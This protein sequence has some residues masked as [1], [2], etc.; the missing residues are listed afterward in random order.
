V[1]RRLVLAVV[2]ATAAL[3]TVGC[4][5]RTGTSVA[6]KQ[7]SNGDSRTARPLV[8][9]STVSAELDSLAAISV[10]P[11]VH[12]R[13]GQCFGTCEMRLSLYRTSSDG[14]YQY[15]GTRWAGGGRS[16]AIVKTVRTTLTDEQATAM[17]TAVVDAGLFTLV[18]DT[19]MMATDLPY[20]WVRAGGG[21]TAL[22]VDRAYI[23]G[24]RYIENNEALMR[25]YHGVVTAL[26]VPL[27]STGDQ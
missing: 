13:V 4:A 26:A 23:G 5:G 8:D 14:A 1:S 10:G 19:T 22:R 17:L 2:F 18:D 25:A 6:E 11:Y 27:E 7:A 3:I 21:P 20:I 15:E 9:E 12:V 24:E 16:E